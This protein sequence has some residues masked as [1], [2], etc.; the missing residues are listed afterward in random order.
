MSSTT[1]GTNLLY[2]LPKVFTL[3]VVDST[4][5][6]TNL[7][8]WLPKVFT[9][10]VVDSTTSGTNLLYSE[11]PFRRHY[12]QKTVLPQNSQELCDKTIKLTGCLGILTQW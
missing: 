6:G 9:L 3:T 10:T 11:S 5:S 12:I 2:R 4:T 7:L 1:S 8:N